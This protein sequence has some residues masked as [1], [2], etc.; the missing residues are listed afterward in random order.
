MSSTTVRL[1]SEHAQVLKELAQQAGEPMQVV[2]G[3]AIEEL[4][5]KMLLEATNKAF[6][7]L[8]AQPLIWQGEV[9]ERAEWEWTL[10]DDLEEKK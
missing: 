1:S 7:A 5:R 2:L 4:R 10:A 6:A 8:K 3:K 9:A